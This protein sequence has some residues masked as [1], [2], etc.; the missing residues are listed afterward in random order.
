M[1]KLLGLAF[2]LVSVSAMAAPKE[3]GACLQYKT[4]QNEWSKPRYKEVTM[5]TG[6]EIDELTGCQESFGCYNDT[7]SNYI[8][9]APWANGEYTVLKVARSL[10]FKSFMNSYSDEM[11]GDDGKVWRLVE[12]KGSPTSCPKH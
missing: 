3:F 5:G 12:H 9:I 6:E 7:F 2:L 10:M 8:L 1:K 4:S 11:K